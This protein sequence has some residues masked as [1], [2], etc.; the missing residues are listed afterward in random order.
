MSSDYT[1]IFWSLESISG[2]IN[3]SAQNIH[4]LISHGS[5]DNIMCCCNMCVCVYKC[6]YAHVD[7]SKTSMYVSSG[8]ST[9]WMLLLLNFSSSDGNAVTS[10]M[11]HQATSSFSV[12][13]RC[14]VHLTLRKSS[15][16]WKSFHCMSISSL[17]PKPLIHLCCLIIQ[18][19]AGHAV[20]IHWLFPKLMIRLIRSNS[21]ILG[22]SNTCQWV[23][24]ETD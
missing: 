2:P 19:N 3:P 21:I 13:V 23:I 20:Y 16:S 6:T 11:C 18:G 7:S 24:P 4:D 22:T 1:S 15:T 8:C 10:Q 17:G 9:S 5:Q 14:P 12:L